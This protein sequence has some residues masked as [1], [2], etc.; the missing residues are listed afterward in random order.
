M[1]FLEFEGLAQVNLVRREILQKSVNTSE[2]CHV[3]HLLVVSSPIW[4]LITAVPKF[5]N[6]LFFY[7]AYEC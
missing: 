3:G 2:G 1:S 6:T 5:V 7:A 4:V